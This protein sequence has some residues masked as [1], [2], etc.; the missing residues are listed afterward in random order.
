MNIP[1]SKVRIYDSARERI[2]KA[3]NTGI[4]AQGP[5]VAELEKLFADR[6]EVEHA[7]AV[8]NGTTALVLALEV[9]DLKPG[10]EVITT[11]FTFAATLNAIIESGATAKFVDIGED[12]LMNVDLISSAITPRTRAIL[13]VHLF[14]Q[15]VDMDA[16]TKSLDTSQ[17]IEIVEDAAQAV[18]AK[19]QGRPAGNFGLGCFSLYATKNVGC[20]EGGMI[21]TNNSHLAE[22]MRI[23]RNQGMRA[24]YEY[25]VPGHNYRLTDLHA[26]VAI[27]QMEDIDGII[28]ARA[29][30]AAAL[31]EGLGGLEGLILPSD[32]QGDV[33]VWNQ[34]TIRVTNDAP[35]TRDDL[36][37]ALTEKGIGTGIYYPSVV[38]DYDCYKSH[39]L[40]SISQVP[41]AEE[42]VG[43]CLSIPVH[44]SLSIEDVEFVIATIREIWNR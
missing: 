33:H 18:G 9:L 8:N 3:L 36:V 30:N 27:P 16:L 23:L 26:A 2:D 5:Q 29:R 31:I 19:F 37:T 42:L 12:F 44:P 24:R 10:D 13:P 35:I 21:T 17:G 41:V 25:V 40:V 1:I 32:R 6:S 28:A 34:F 14:G 4:L 15:M 38:F 43:T 11:P 7:I 39:P 22:R 20:G